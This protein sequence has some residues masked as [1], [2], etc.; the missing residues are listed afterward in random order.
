MNKFDFDVLLRR[1]PSTETQ[2]L[3]EWTIYQD[4]IKPIYDC[5]TIELEVDCNAKRDDAIP[6][7][8]YRVIKRWSK[9]YGNHFH[10]LNVPN[11]SYIL[12]HNANYSRQLL[13]CVAVGRKHA[14]IDGDGLQDVTSSKA[15]L[16]ELNELLPE[17][18]ILKI[19]QDEKEI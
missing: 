5:K 15:T 4:R 2:T 6:N 13:G 9:K 3:G 19:I 7:G 11:R 18:F 1:Q 14:D 16:K 10:I 8:Y 17:Q 12:I